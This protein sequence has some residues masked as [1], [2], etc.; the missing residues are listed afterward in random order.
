M[1][2]KSLF[3]GVVVLLLISGIWTH[4]KTSNLHHPVKVEDISSITLWGVHGGYQ[5]AT[6]TEGATQE[7]I[8][9]IVNWFN[10]VSDIR[11]NRAFAGETP[12]SGIIIKEKNGEEFSIIRSG[13]D[14]EVQRKNKSG[15]TY[16]YWAI[17]KEIKK[18]LDELAQ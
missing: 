15:E 18:L 4:V 17:Q 2:K 1:V 12:D 13:K 5:E 8:K 10:S 3:I 6:Q 9:N 11:E 14:F 16:S 7:E